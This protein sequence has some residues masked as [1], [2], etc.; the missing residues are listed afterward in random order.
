MKKETIIAIFFGLLLGGAGALFLIVKNKE[1]QLEKTNTMAP[2]LKI[3]PSI[4]KNN[5]LVLALNVTEPA[6]GTIVNKDSVMIKGKATKGSLIMIQ[7]PIKDQ[8]FKTEKDDFSVDFPLAFG[9]N[10]ILVT[11]YPADKQLPSQ[12]K[13]L[14]VYYMQEQ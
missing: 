5:G 8:V 14:K 4:V 10:T 13:E 12:E 6:D 1:I 11:L 7:S 3:S 2:V 9:E